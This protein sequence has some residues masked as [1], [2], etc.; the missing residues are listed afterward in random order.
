MKTWRVWIENRSHRTPGRDVATRTAR[1]LAGAL[2]TAAVLCGSIMT[3]SPVKA[4]GSEAG[5]GLSGSSVSSAD[6]RPLSEVLSFAGEIDR[7]VQAGYREHAVVPNPP[8][9][10]E[11]VLRRIYLAIIGRTP[12]YQEAKGFL[13]SDDLMKRPRLI[14]RLLDSEGYVSRNFNYWADLLRAKTRLR[15]APGPLYLDYIKESIRENKPYDQFVRELITAEGYV[16][17]DGAAGYYLRDPGMPLDNMANTV[18]IFLGTQ[19]GCAQC[20][21]H[22]YDS[23][24]QKDFYGMAAYT[25][26]V[27]TRDRRT[28]KARELRA[29][30]R[31]DKVSPEVLQA[32]R[33]LVRP[34]TYRVHELRRTLKLPDDYQYEDAEPKSAVQPGT[35]FGENAPATRSR[36]LRGSYADWL[37]S[38]ENPRFTTVIANR[39]WKREF[40]LG[41][42]EPV[43]DFRD[44]VTPSNPALMDYLTGLMKTLEYDMKQYLRVLYNSKT[45]QRQAVETVPDLDDGGRFHFE[46]PLLTRMSAEQIWDSVAA[47]I[48]PDIDERRNPNPPDR[49]YQR[50][51]ELVT[52]TP[53]ELVMTAARRVKGRKAQA[54]QRKELEG[55]T[56]QLQ[57]AR[58]SGRREDINRLQKR[59]AQVR[60]SYG[61]GAAMQS[62]SMGRGRGK[63]GETTGSNDSRWR[64]YSR[65]L[66]RAS[67]L[68]SPA[69]PGHFL[70]Q[71][72]QSDRETIENADNAANVP[73]ILTLLNGEVYGQ[74]SEPRAVLARDLK[75]AESAEEKLEVATLSILS[76]RPTAKD[77]AVL[78]PEIKERGAEGLEDV[79]WAL[80]N[81]RQFLFIQ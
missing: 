77:R 20:H 41:V 4:G 27:E 46:G 48:V 70:Q 22:P 81:T 32:T 45:Y 60:T 71:F 14:D 21:D 19:L 29:L 9:S 2:L 11:V 35:L 66:V 30:A 49:R 47:M 50:A 57:A 44:G 28:S 67:E 31:S 42:I 34:L 78:L 69:R 39:L 79:V 54:E 5:S 62:R 73:Q 80:L 33:Q 56:K 61:A 65:Q 13:A 43:D 55:L 63:S 10:D 64:G 59:I 53:T 18:Q 8:A 26:G 74:L 51:E 1:I 12:T 68:E 24:T 7:L 3:I 6:S 72:G 16:W 76:R 37:T 40:G 23:W 36:S 17:E 75:A 52:M 58:R 25:Y 15:N 38:A